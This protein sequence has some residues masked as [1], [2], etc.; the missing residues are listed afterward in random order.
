MSLISVENRAGKVKLDEYVSKDKVDELIGEIDGT[1]GNTV[2]GKTFG[3]Q[4]VVAKADDAIDTLTI[5]INSAGGSVLEGH[6]LFN[7]LVEMRKRGVRV[8]AKITALAGSMAS[9]VAMAADEI[10]MVKG[11]RMMIHEA[12]TITMGDARDHMRMGKLLE[13]M[14]SEIADIYAARTGNEV[15]DVREWMLAETWFGAKEARAKGF[16]DTILGDADSD[17]G[18]HTQTDITMFN[19]R[20]ELAEKVAA[21]ESD[22]ADY[23]ATI[24]DLES[25][26][27]AAKAHAQE[28]QNLQA[29]LEALT[30][31]KTDLVAR[32]KDAEEKA[33]P[34]AIQAKVDAAI[35]AS[36]HEPLEGVDGDE[37]SASNSAES[38][39]D[40]LKRFENATAQDLVNLKRNDP[41]AFARLR[42][43]TD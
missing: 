28:V 11:G 20:K 29:S 30:N 31:E 2:V 18:N 25:K 22:A 4:N 12:S 27:E 10:Q 40:F 1:F 41:D 16:I 19:S 24:K 3:P 9:V 8:V 38:D 36:G 7:S 37:G 14:S 21:L 33:S 17:P 34:E 39:K 15:T 42:A 35:A 26:V 13:E 43:L 32:L 5:E 23:E 6:R